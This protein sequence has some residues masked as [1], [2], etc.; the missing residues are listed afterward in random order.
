[1]AT[2]AR[3]SGLVIGAG[4][5]LGGAWALGAL[6]ALADAEGY[7]AAR[8]DAVVGTSA[9]SVLAA[10]IGSRVPMDDMVRRLSGHHGGLE[11]T[12]PVNA[13]DVEP[14]HVR[15][16]LGT[17]P[18][19]RMLPASPLLAV[20]TFTR[21]YSHTL[22]TLA[23]ALAPQGRGDLTPVRVVLEEVGVGKWPK[24]PQ[25]WI[26]AMDADRGRRVVFGRA[27]APEVPLADAVLAS[28][29]APGYFPPVS[30]DGVR[31]VD[32]GAVSMTNADVLRGA[33]LDEVLVLAPMCVRDAASGRS[34]P[35]RLD[36]RLR[37]YANRRLA[38]EIARLTARG[39][40]VR[41]LAPGAEDWRA[42]GTNVM[43]PRR[44]EAVFE[45][46]VRTTA[47]L[48]AHGRWQ[49]HEAVAG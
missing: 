19:P 21:P 16:S 7:E 46:A 24:R 2:R 27:D 38:S 15:A 39:T 4:A 30:I 47:E 10:M 32:G 18:R 33:E 17:I 11:G 9:G 22:M 1:M 14:D 13:L 40:G 12:G 6:Q 25:T 34:V 5:A 3:R 43:D 36:R 41:V 29:A 35:Q 48:L 45:S 37:G 20:R 28:C 42:M 49:Q 31:Y 26:V 8:A 44:R 23:A